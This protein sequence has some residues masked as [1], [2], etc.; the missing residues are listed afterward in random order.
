MVPACLMEWAPAGCISFVHNGL[1]GQA[2][3]DNG[4]VNSGQHVV[5]PAVDALPSHNTNL[6][7][8][9]DAADENFIARLKLEWNHNAASLVVVKWGVMTES[10]PSHN[11]A[12]AQYSL[13]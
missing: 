2:L 9:A 11:P 6:L 10:W 7:G 1:D 13:P 4:V 8:F 5:R 12:V 3:L